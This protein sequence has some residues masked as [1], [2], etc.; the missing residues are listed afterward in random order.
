MT[1]T[2][3]FSCRNQTHVR[4]VIHATTVSLSLG[5]ARDI[6]CHAA[7]IVSPQRGELTAT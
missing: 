2:T 4:P 3:A 1:G 5:V 7:P 6:C